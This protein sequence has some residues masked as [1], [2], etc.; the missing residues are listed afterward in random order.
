[1]VVARA[2]EEEGFDNKCLMCTEFQF[3]KKQI[4]KAEVVVSLHDTE[5]YT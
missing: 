4:L 5:C 3:G 2:W 1:M